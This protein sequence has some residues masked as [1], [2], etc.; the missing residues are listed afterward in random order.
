MFNPPN[1]YKDPYEHERPLPIPSAINDYNRY[2]G[3]VDIVD[4]LRAS[5]TTQ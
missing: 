5:F 4:Q 1:S 2:M 3:G